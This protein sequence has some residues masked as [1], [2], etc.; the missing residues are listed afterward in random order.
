MRD[1]ELPGPLAASDLALVIEPVERP[2]HAANVPV[3]LGSSALGTD[4]IVEL[5][6]TE[7]DGLHRIVPGDRTRIPFGARDGCRLVFHR[8]RIPA[9]AGA[10]LLNLDIDVAGTDGTPR[11]EAHVAQPIILRHAA[12]PRLAWIKGVQQPFDKITVHLAHVV[13]ESHYVGAD[14]LRTGA[15]SVQW[16]ILAGTGHARLYATTA[17]PT[18]LYRVSDREHSGIL[19]LNFGALAR[20]TWLDQEGHAGFL[21][22]EGGIMGV[23]LANDQSTEGKSLTQVAAVFG[24]GLSVPIANRGGATETSVNLHAWYEFEPARTTSDV[25][26]NPSAFVFGPSISIG[27]IGTNL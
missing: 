3:S 7:D 1:P 23:G 14:E 17:I 15:P 5:V 9:E 10:Q 8:E 24:V 27:N 13:D 18:G 11:P 12:T 19:A 4:P 20:L 22:L 26:G 2:L 16:G 25:P 6:C 21:G